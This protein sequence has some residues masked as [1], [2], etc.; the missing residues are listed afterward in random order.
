ML[1]ALEDELSA[2]R[3]SQLSAPG[4]AGPRVSQT[5]SLVRTR[6]S[7]VGTGQAPMAKWRHEATANLMSCLS[8]WVHEPPKVYTFSSV[9]LRVSQTGVKRIHSA[10]KLLCVEGT[11]LPQD[12]RAPFG[13]CATCSMQLKHAHPFPRDH[14]ELVNVYTDAKYV[15]L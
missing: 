8:C 1:A 15:T 10:T 5:R 6:S 4:A 14:D 9:G 2:S 3:C 13:V 11:A 7:A 12:F